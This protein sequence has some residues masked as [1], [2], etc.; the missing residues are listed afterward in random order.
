MSALG[1]FEVIFRLIVN[2]VLAFIFLYIDII[3]REN[4]AHQRGDIVLLAI[5]VYAT[6]FMLVKTCLA[7]YHHFKWICCQKCCTT[8]TEDKNR[9]GI[10]DQY[11]KKEYLEWNN[12]YYKKS[13]VAM[14]SVIVKR[15]NRF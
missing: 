8:L 14:P 3:S 5:A 12:D 15:P 2:S 13:Q 9:L 6:V 1:N 4:G 7:I 11:W 10:I